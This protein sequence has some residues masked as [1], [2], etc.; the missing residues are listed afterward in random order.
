[1]GLWYGTSCS[2]ASRFRSVSSVSGKRIEMGVVVGFRLGKT[3][4]RACVQSK[5]SVVSAVAQNFCSAASVANFG[6][7][8][9]GAD[10]VAP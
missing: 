4:R 3:T 10:P 8:G 5:Y 9:Q 6:I 2:F 1:M 7:G